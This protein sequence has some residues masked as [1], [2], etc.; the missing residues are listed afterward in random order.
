MVARFQ[1]WNVADP[2]G[3]R[4]CLDDPGGRVQGSGTHRFFTADAARA[5]DRLP[6]APSDLGLD[7]A[8]GTGH[9]A[10]QLAPSVAVMVAVDATA[11]MLDRGREQARREGLLNLVYMRG[12]AEALPFLAESFDVT[13][14]RFA[15]HHFERPE[16][17][18]PSWLAAPASAG[19]WRS[20]T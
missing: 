4:A 5:F 19:T 1:V 7:V 10:R 3:D 13:V 16:A 15:M 6:R 9:A 17:V 11:A 18:S 2:A 20:S 12:E 14:C 8:A